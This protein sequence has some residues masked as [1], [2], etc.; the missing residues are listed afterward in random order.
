MVIVRSTVPVG[1]NKEVQRIIKTENPSLKFEIVSNPEFSKQG[2]SIK[3]FLQ[4]DR[5]VIGVENELAKNTMYK[6]Y[7]PID[8]AGY[9]IVFTSIETAELIKYA[10][11]AFLAVKIG[12][13]NEMCDLCR[14]AG[15]DIKELAKTMGMDTRIGDKFLNPGP[16]YGGSCFPKDTAALVNIA[17]DYKVKMNIVD[18]TIKANKQRKKNM[19]LLIQEA[20]GKSVEGKTICILGLAFKANTDDTRYSPALV[21]IEELIKAGAKIK[22]YD[23]EATAKAKTMLSK[24]ALNNVE[25]CKDMYESMKDS[26]VVVILTEWDEFKK[27]DFSKASKLVSNN[28]LVD[29]RNIIDKNKASKEGFKYYSLC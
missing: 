4:P 16:G 24:N 13:I 29:L 15:A 6:L 5:V 11:N 3:D 23:P 19:A 20:Y 14:K 9:P 27:I 28:I 7:E 1:T 18:A 12:F 26:E 25:F 17:K 22:T 10:S 21:V 8:R 2:T